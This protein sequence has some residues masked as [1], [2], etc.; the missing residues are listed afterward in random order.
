MANSGYYIGLMSGTSMDGID[1]ALVEISDHGTT[2]LVQAISHPWPSS[3]ESR[4]RDQV[5]RKS[6]TLHEYGELDHLCGQQFALAV[7]ALLKASDMDSDNIQAIGSHGQTLYHHPYPPSP[8]TLQIGDPSIIAERTGITVVADFRRRDMAA[9]GQGA[10][11][12]PAF[13][14]AIF[15]HPAKNRVILNIGGI[16]NITLLPASGKAVQGFDTGPGN[17]LMDLWC[18]RNTGLPYD[19]D[20]D[21]ASRGNPHA[22]LLQKMLRDDYFQLPPPK[23]TGTEYFNMQWL[24]ERLEAFPGIPAVDVQATLLA[25]TASTI[26]QALRRWAPSTGEI[27]VCGGGIHNLTLLDRLR[28]LLSPMQVMATDDVD[29]GMNPDWI[30]AAAFAWLARQTLAGLPGNLPPVTGASHPVVL[31]GIY[32]ASGRVS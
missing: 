20:G 23:S 8:F 12:V 11:L 10:P 17:C 27:L 4:L 9:G 5:A 32:P 18:T 1:A 6:C 13:H 16:A 24:E 21:W 2:R 31:G 15:Q 3:L 22:G 29:N 30:E 26:E 7:L 25:F 14:Q 19:E 28:K